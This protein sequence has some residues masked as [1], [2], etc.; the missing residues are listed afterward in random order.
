MGMG[1]WFIC[2]FTCYISKAS[3]QPN[4]FCPLLIMEIKPNEKYYRVCCFAQYI[5]MTENRSL[6]LQHIY[7]MHSLY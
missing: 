2:L 3:K 6:C 1:G 4:M 5:G 7:N